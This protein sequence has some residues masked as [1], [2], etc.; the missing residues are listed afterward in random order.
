MQ[1]AFVGRRLV[2]HKRME[3][4]EGNR[5]GLLG[6]LINYVE[7]LPEVASV[8][9]HYSGSVRDIYSDFAVSCKDC[10]IA[11]NVTAGD[12]VQCG[13]VSGSVRAS[14]SV[15]CGNVKGNVT[16]GDGV[17]CGDIGGDPRRSASK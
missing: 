12:S 9:L 11:G 13:D 15:D 7:R 2:G 3:R 4:G 16:A 17:T 1:S 14:D 8:V 5:G 6:R 10:D